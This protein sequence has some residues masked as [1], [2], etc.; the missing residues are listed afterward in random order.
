M[1]EEQK[2]KVNG[3]PISKEEFEEKKKEL[4]NKKGVQLVEQGPNDYRIR[5]NG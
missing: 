4:Q 5:I 3:Q 2:I 1:S